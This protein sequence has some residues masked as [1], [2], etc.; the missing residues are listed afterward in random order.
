MIGAVVPATA[1]VDPYAHHSPAVRVPEALIR[2]LPVGRRAIRIAVPSAAT[3][4]ARAG[5]RSL[6][7]RQRRQIGQH[8]SPLVRRL[9]PRHRLVP[10]LELVEPDPAGRRVLLQPFV[11]QLPIG[12]AGQHAVSRRRPP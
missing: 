11:R 7:G 8:R 10:A 2:R 5:R 3:R 4:P 9:R 12:V 6:I 1:P